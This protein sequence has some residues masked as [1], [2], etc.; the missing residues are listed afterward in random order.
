MNAINVAKDMM[1]E[2]GITG[3]FHGCTPVLFGSALYRGVMLSSYEFAFTYAHLNF[4]GD[5]FV[6]RRFY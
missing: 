3:F 2:F 5:H 4:D 6:K 1:K